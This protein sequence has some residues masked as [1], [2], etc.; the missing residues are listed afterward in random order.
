MYAS[1]SS[2]MPG[3]LNSFLAHLPPETIN[4]VIR[5]D[6]GYEFA[7]KESKFIIPPSVVE[8]TNQAKQF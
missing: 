1:F 5:K 4:E 2:K 7:F 6:C 3:A 8:L